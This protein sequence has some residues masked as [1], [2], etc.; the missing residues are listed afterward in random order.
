MNDA[1]N[2]NARAPAQVGFKIPPFDATDPEVWFAIVESYFHV[3]SITNERTR[4][5]YVVAAMDPRVVQEVRDLIINPPETEPY[6]KLKDELKKRLSVS[7][8]AK[9]RRV[10]EGEELGDRK[11]S[12]FLRHLRSLAGTAFSDAVLR[13]LWLKRLPEPMQVILATQRKGSL[14]EAAELADAIA[15]TVVSRLTVAETS[16]S[17]PATMDAKFQKLRLSMKEEL[18]QDI[19]ELIAEVKSPRNFERGRP[20]PRTLPRSRSQSREHGECWY[21][22]TFGR[23]S[24]KC[25]APCSFYS[26]NDS[27][28]R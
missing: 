9:T 22:R 26:G 10:I 28:S 3:A 14:E 8:E 13:S 7:Q 19:R 6:S 1:Q 4:F 18:R 16:T 21:H 5:N 12:Q 11:P 24:K 17:A 27:G 23:E 25:R 20:R 2:G 15:D